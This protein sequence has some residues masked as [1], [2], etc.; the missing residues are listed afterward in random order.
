MLNESLLHDHPELVEHTR[1]IHIDDVRVEHPGTAGSAP[2]RWGD[3]VMIS[4]DYTAFGRV[5]DVIFDLEIHHPEGTMLLCVDSYDCGT[6]YDI[7]EG[8]GTVSFEFPAWPLGDGAMRMSVGIKSRHETE[9]YDWKENAGEIEA[10]S[11][12]RRAAALIVKAEVSSS[13]S[14]IPRLRP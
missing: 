3:P 12:N 7:D 5:D 11:Q 10:I 14:A 4:V 8:A 2:L 1:L 9:I 6:V 13:G